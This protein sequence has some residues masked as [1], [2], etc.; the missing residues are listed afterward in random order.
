M[1]VVNIALLLSYS[2]F[3]PTR[4]HTVTTCERIIATYARCGLSDALPLLYYPQRATSSP[5]L[6]RPLVVVNAVFHLDRQYRPEQ[7]AALIELCFGPAFWVGIVM[8]I[9]CVEWYLSS[10]SV[11]GFPLQYSGKAQAGPNATASTK[12]II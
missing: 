7:N 3:T 10:P 9:L 12:K 6:A 11:R 4:F 5:A 2:K 8:N 1:R